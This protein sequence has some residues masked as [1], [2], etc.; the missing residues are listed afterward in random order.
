[1]RASLPPRCLRPLRARPTG[2]LTHKSPIHHRPIVGSVV[3]CY[4][5][6]DRIIERSGLTL[7][8]AYSIKRLRLSVRVN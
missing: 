4:R 3:D 2:K 7:V 1:M 8:F 5:H 6:V